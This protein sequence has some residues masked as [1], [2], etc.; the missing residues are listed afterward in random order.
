MK[1]SLNTTAIKP[2]N[3]EENKPEQHPLLNKAM[4]MLDGE[5]I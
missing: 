1:F 2:D 3:N 4:D 5:E